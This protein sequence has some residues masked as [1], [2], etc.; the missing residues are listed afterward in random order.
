MEVHR[1]LSPNSGQIFLADAATQREDSP[2][3][4][5]P[6]SK[7]YIHSTADFRQSAAGCSQ[8]EGF[9]KPLG[10]SPH[11]L[12]LCNTVK[13]PH[14]HHNGCN[15][16]AAFIAG[17]HT[18]NK[19][20]GIGQVALFIQMEQENHIFPIHRRRYRQF[21]GF[22]FCLMQFHKLKTGYTWLCGHRTQFHQRMHL[23]GIDRVFSHS[24]LL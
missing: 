23:K 12:F 1:A 5:Q 8:Q 18:A 6:Q 21:L 17:T 2:A 10:I 19:S 3:Q 15:P 24:F 22:Q 14:G 16:L 13:M 7:G 20:T 4:F 9:I 11:Q